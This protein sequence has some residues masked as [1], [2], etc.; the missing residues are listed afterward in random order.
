M[1]LKSQ[2]EQRISTWP[3]PEHE[4]TMQIEF[5]LDNIGKNV[6]PTI[7]LNECRQSCNQECLNFTCI[8]GCHAVLQQQLSK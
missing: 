1:L 2:T 3:L 4:T 5:F 6:V 7:P 8:S